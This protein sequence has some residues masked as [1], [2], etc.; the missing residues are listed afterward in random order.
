MCY[1]KTDLIFA[2][3]NYDQTVAFKFFR[4][5]F[6]SKFKCYC[7]FINR[8]IQSTLWFLNSLNSTLPFLTFV[9][10]SKYIHFSFI[11]LCNN[12]YP[13]LLPRIFFLFTLSDDCNISLENTLTGFVRNTFGE[14]VINFHVSVPLQNGIHINI[15]GS[16]KI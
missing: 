16:R 15:V 11:I 13:Q 1:T 2:S 8:T 7:M 4:L 9:T 10:I 14:Y 12:L 3:H 5:A 6:L